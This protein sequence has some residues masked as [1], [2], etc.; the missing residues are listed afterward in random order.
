MR[1][2][3]RKPNR[4]LTCLYAIFCILYLSIGV[5]TAEASDSM[6]TGRLEIPA[7]SLDSVVTTLTLEDNRLSTPE[8]IVGAFSIH[9]NKTLLIAHSVTA[10]EHLDQLK[11]GDKLTYNDVSYVVTSLETKAKSDISM[12]EILESAPKETLVLMTCA[13]KLL[14]DGDA[15]HRLLVTARISRP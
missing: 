8:R 13:G 11:I 6:I 15:T 5:Q 9:T 14:P 2:E 1:I 7:I 12:S 10:F 4:F 3:S